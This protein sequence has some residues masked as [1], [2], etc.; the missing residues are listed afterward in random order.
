[1]KQPMSPKTRDI[2]YNF[3][4]RHTKTNKYGYPIGFLWRNYWVRCIDD[5]WQHFCGYGGPRLPRPSLARTIKGP[6]QRRKDRIEV[7]QD[8]ERRNT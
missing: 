3:R 8:N 7:R 6:W 1:M 4:L 5:R 2:L